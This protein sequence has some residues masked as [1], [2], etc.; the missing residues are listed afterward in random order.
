MQEFRDFLK[1]IMNKFDFM[2]YMTGL[3]VMALMGAVAWSIMFRTV[4]VENKELFSHLIGIVEGAFVGGLV[5]YYY[6][7]SKSDKP[8]P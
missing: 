5:Q 2:Q 4:P 6:G 8:Q 3:F 7:K 1:S